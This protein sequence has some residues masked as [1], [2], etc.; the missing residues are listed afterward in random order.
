MQR[1][2]TV[3]LDG[4]AFLFSPWDVSEVLLVA[5]GQSAH[6]PTM[7]MLHG[8]LIGWRWRSW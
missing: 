4:L 1:V 5:S 6:G 3:L 7:G 2:R 8:V